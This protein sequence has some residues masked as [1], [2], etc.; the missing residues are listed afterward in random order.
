M[1]NNNEMPD[2]NGPTTVN[3]DFVTEGTLRPPTKT[4]EN[5]FNNITKDFENVKLPERTIPVSKIEELL[6]IAETT[7]TK[8]LQSPALSAS[9]KNTVLASF[10][11]WKIQLKE[12]IK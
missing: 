12:L 4:E 7:Q 2:P 1:E 9:Q 10:E 6:L 5:F 11:S 8:I 3:V